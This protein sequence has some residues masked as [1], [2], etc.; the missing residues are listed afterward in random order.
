MSVCLRGRRPR[1]E[2][3]QLGVN[4]SV[5]GLAIIE[6]FGRG[7]LAANQAVQALFGVF[8]FAHLLVERGIVVPQGVDGTRQ[9]ASEKPAGQIQTLDRKSVV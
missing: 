8:Q 5:L 7:P 2:L 4:L 9:E 6:C 1:L 3:F